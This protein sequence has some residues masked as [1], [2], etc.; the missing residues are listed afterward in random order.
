[1]ASTFQATGLS[2]YLWITGR[3][4]VLCSGPGRE[5]NYDSLYKAFDIET[6]KLLEIVPQKPLL[7]SQNSK[8]KCFRR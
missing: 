5:G 6:Q 7:Q 4:A 3:Y 2:G 1:M 8:L